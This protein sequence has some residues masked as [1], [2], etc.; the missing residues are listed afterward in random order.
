MSSPTGSRSSENSPDSSGSGNGDSSSK[1]KQAPRSVLL[2]TPEQLQR[3]RAQDRESQRQ[4]RARVKQTIAE[5]ER[6]VEMLTE[7]LHLIRLENASLQEKNQLAPPGTIR[8]ASAVG[9]PHPIVEDPKFFPEGTAAIMD[10]V[11]RQ[12]SRMS[13]YLEMG[14]QFSDSMVIAGQISTEPASETIIDP[15]L[16]NLYQDLEQQSL[17][18][19]VWKARPIHYPATCKYDHIVLDLMANLKPLYQNGGTTLEFAN[20]SFPHIS[21]LLN[22]QQHSMMYPLAAEIV[23]KVIYVFTIDSLPEQIAIMWNMC[24]LLRWMIT[25]SEEDYYDMP[26]WMRPTA[27]QVVTAHPTWVDMYPWPKSRDRLC[28]NATY[29]DKYQ[30]LTNAANE[31]LSINWPYKPEDTLIKISPSEY[32]I[33]PVFLTHLRNLDNWTVGAAF[34]EEYPEFEHEVKIG[35]PRLWGPAYT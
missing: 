24:T 7:E 31:T 22:P 9:P 26:D 1:P 4:T 32:T 25:G 11:V 20:P 10:V 14:S 15:S 28:R 6:R 30:A 19:P 29:H 2:L 5:L 17:S 16:F 23:S 27:T 21:A 8:S 18:M 13:Q 33:N 34:I 3:K 12:Q 35:K